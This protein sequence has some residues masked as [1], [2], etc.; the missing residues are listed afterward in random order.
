MDHFKNVLANDVRIVSSLP[1]T[2]LMTRPVEE[3]RT[4]LHASPQWIRSRYLKRV[5]EFVAVLCLLFLILLN[6]LG[7][8]S[9]N[10]YVEEEKSLFLWLRQEFGF[11][12]CCLKLSATLDLA[13]ELQRH[14]DDSKSLN[15]SNEFT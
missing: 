15:I 2:H 7:N 13:F 1:S 3:K 5:S 11:Y 12:N 9:N 6:E 14:W 8:N 4:P 10:K